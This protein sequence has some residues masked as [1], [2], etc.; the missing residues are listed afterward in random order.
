M[1]DKKIPLILAFLALSLAACNSTIHKRFSIEDEKPM[2]VS[3]DAKQRLVLVSRRSDKGNP[4][5]SDSH[6]VVCAEPSPDALVSAAAAGSLKAGVGEKSLGVTGALAETA[7]NI[8]LRTQTIQ[9]LRDGLY[10]ACEAYLNKAIGAQAYQEILRSID[11]VMITLLAIEALTRPQVAPPIVIGGK[12]E[13][14]NKESTTTTAESKE[15]KIDITSNVKASGV[16]KEVADVVGKILG[17][18]YKVQEARLAC[19]QDKEC[20]KRLRS[21]LKA[22]DSAIGGPSAE[23][24]N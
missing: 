13:A 5:N 3:V 17:S 10:R 20:V 12:A 14:S 21:V 16:T 15:V 7:A 4:S 6:I 8:G 18:Y 24:S 9:L 1:C 22:L 11:D 23:S 19:A 2:S